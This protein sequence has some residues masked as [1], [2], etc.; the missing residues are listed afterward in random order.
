MEGKAMGARHDW[1]AI[2]RALRVEG[3]PVK[4]ILARFRVPASTFYYQ[5]RKRRWP[6]PLAGTKEGLRAKPEVEL[7]ERLGRMALKRLIALER[8]DACRENPDAWVRSADGALK[9]LER[10]D[11]IA[12]SEAYR[13]ARRPEWTQEYRD[14]KREELAQ[15]VHAM[16]AT[17]RGVSAEKAAAAR[18]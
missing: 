13:R 4:N 3:M 2:E 18:R 8:P 1:G 16:L 6:L 17:L 14:R 5:A 7:L 11:A 9:L 10:M 15:R 12:A